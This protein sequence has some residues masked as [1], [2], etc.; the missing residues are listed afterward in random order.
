MRDVKAVLTRLAL[1]LACFS[2]FL[3]AVQAGAVLHHAA[4]TLPPLAGL[5]ETLGAGRWDCAVLIG[6][7]QN[8]H[9][10]E[11]TLRQFAS[12]SRVSFF[13]HSGMSF[14]QALSG[15]FSAI[16]RNVRILPLGSVPAET[17][18]A[19]DHGH[20][21]P[22]S[23]LDPDWLGVAAEQVSAELT[24]CD[25]SGAEAYTQALAGYRKR[26]ADT[27]ADLKSR[28]YAG[29]AFL[30]CHPAYSGFAEATG[31]EQLALEHEGKEPGPRHL[32]GLLTRARELDA[33]VLVLQSKTEETKARPFLRSAGNLRTAFVSPL[34]RDALQTLRML[35]DALSEG[36]GEA[37]AK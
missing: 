6:E 4:A 13:A 5:V 3:P 37:E 14:E 2:F 25:P 32:A 29:R 30:V 1:F 26:L 11:P 17:A 23:W 18:S 20:D 36:R 19:V 7:G 15:R 9:T 22:H 28:T 27:V 8:P 34:G 16:Y 12:V 24:R 35:A 21:E 10:Y 33:R 31:L